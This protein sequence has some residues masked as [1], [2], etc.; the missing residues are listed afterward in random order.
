MQTGRDEVRPATEP[1]RIEKQQQ[2]SLDEM[3]K[4]L[5]KDCNVGTKKNSKGYK[6]TWIGYKAHVD[7]I[8]GDIPVSVI[9]TSASLHDSQ[10]AIPLAEE[11][12]NK[13]TSLYDLMDAAYDVREIKDHSRRLGHVPII[14]PNPRRN[15]G[16]KKALEQE[17]LAQRTLNWKPAEKKRYNQRSSAERVNARLKDEF[18]GRNVR[19]RGNKKVYCHLMFGFLALAADQFL[20]LIR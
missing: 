4:D 8:D 6:E 14:D 15:T 3:V 1:T 2:M 18:G 10:V 11:T 19:V 20:N 16:L 9:L 7:T 17:N 5:P 12:A 13:I